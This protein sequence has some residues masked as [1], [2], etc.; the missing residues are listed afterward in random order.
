[1]L[2]SKYI[3]L[4]LIMPMILFAQNSNDTNNGTEETPGSTIY[5][6]LDE[7]ENVLDFSPPNQMVYNE[8]G[9][10]DFAN[11]TPEEI[12]NINIFLQAIRQGDRTTVEGQI[13]Q[14]INPNVRVVQDLEKGM[15]ALMVAVSERREDMIELL[16]FSGA[17]PNLTTHNKKIEGLT[18]L[19][20]A[21]IKGPV[22]IVDLLIRYEADVDAQTEGIVAGSTPLMAA[23]G[24]Q[25]RTIV[26]R[27]LASEADVNIKTI[28]GSVYGIT[29][30]MIASQ[31]ED[32]EI[33]K[34]LIATPSIQINTVDSENKSALVYAVISGDME[35]VK[36]LLDNG[37]TT[38]LTPKELQEI[39]K[40]YL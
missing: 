38:T 40:K 30:L 39:V 35:T 36:I 14:G 5:Q 28:G 19:M 26:N 21:S 34:A 20:V 24:A 25:Q 6:T 13:E 4:L 29:A 15:T 3:I 22:S 9:K 10:K 17:N 8:E 12:S 1:M 18:A 33:L 11:F 16:L 7:I 27:L 31:H 23:V 32:K 37:A 2:L